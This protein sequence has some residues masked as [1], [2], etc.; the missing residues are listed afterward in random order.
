DGIRCQHF[1]P[2][3]V[4]RWLL[5]LIRTTDL[6]VPVGDEF[7]VRLRVE[8]GRAGLLCRLRAGRSAV[9]RGRQQYQVCY[10]FRMKCRVAARSRTAERPRQNADL[11]DMPQRSDVVHGSADIV[12]V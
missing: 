12:P 10:F 3:G 8:G 11:V 2:D 6:S 9:V 4:A 1:G 7:A 5:I